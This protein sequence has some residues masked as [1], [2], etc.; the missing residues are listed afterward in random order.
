MFKKLWL[1]WFWIICIPSLAVSQS[2]NVWLQIEAHPSVIEAEQQA[3]FYG[4]AIAD[5]SAFAISGGWYAVTIGPLDEEDAESQ[6]LKLRAAGAIPLDSFISRGTNFEQKIW[7]VRFET[8]E[9]D[10]TTP[11]EETTAPAKPSA[12][13]PKNS[14][15]RLSSEA[16]ETIEEARAIEATLTKDEKK[17]LQVALKWAGYYT[18]SIDGAFGP[19]TRAAMGAWQKAES[20]A[21]TKIM[22][23]EQRDF[24]LAQYNEILR[25]LRLESISDLEAGIALKIPMNIVKFQKYSPPLVYFGSFTGT[26]HS[27]YMISQEGSTADL[28]ALY[29]ALQSLDT[30]PQT[31][32]RNLKGDSFEINGQNNQLFSYA[33]ASLKSGQIKG[34]VLV[35]PADDAAQHERLLTEMKK[36]FETFRG[37]LDPDM[38]DG[39]IQT[40]DLLFGLE[41]RKP[42]FSRSGVFV[43]AKGHIVTDAQGLDMC[44]R[45]TIENHFDAQI[46]AIDPSRT[47]AIIATKQAVSPPE[48]A[49][50]S[51]YKPTI[52]DKIIAAGYSY[53][54]I[55]AAPSV[56]VGEVDD[57]KALNGNTDFMRLNIAM[58][59]GDVGGPVLNKFGTLSGIMTADRTEGRS[60]P[61]KVHHAIKAKTVVSLMNEVGQFVTYKK[62]QQSVKK[63]LIER[64]ARNITG[65]VSC[66]KD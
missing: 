15:I 18:S 38:G 26:Q 65:L 33:T 24:L 16:D 1:F 7:P 39:R 23:S 12:V 14:L 44:D 29:E 61:K 20:V 32:E 6:L 62:L 45:I 60:L 4:A 31:G 43:T 64:E 66:W 56:L 46:I 49:E 35:W 27:V 51:L 58:M 2:L 40:S 47:L 48:V 5:V 21:P 13:T 50:I 41:I 17:Q 42:A 63:I 9:S 37:T 57:L 30:I 19:G 55:L 34:F 8:N 36:S 11:S 22:T 53:E 54:G 52:G 3:R 59:T 10:I 28:K 25:S